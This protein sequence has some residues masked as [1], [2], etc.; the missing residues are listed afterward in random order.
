MA[1]KKVEEILKEEKELLKKRIPQIVEDFRKKGIKNIVALDRSGRPIGLLVYKAWKKMYP[2]ENPKLFFISPRN[3]LGYSK[4]EEVPKEI[5]KE[6][7]DLHLRI[8]KEENPQLYKKIKNKEKLGIVDEVEYSGIT[9]KAS[10]NFFK[11][12][13][14]KENVVFRSYENRRSKDYDGIPYWYGRED[15][16]GVKKV[17][18]LTDNNLFENKPAFVSEKRKTEG[19]EGKKERQR[20][21]KFRKGLNRLSEEIAS[22]RIKQNKLKPRLLNRRKK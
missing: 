19:E 6:A 4:E 18:P 9:K 2:D 16:I 10:L 13:V 12:L 17:K 7:V 8:L 3:I 15:L 14:G 1:L 5:I 11:R 22:Q 20:L 21:I